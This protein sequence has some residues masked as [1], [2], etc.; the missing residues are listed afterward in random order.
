[1]A[2]RDKFAEESLETKEMLEI[3]ARYSQGKASKE[4]MKIANEQFRD[5]IRALGL[6]A[7][8]VLPFAPLTI[9]L[10]VKISQKLGIEILPSSFRR[11]ANK[12]GHK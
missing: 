4:E 3:Y 7:F 11:P 8:I 2:L 12:D 9:P 10:I 5:L 6:S 1:M